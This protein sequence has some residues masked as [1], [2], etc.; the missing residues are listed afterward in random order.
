[1]KK[2][3]I[4]YDDAC[5]MCS[6]YTSAFVKTGLLTR[7][8][9]QSFSGM[10]DSL[11]KLI[12]SNKCRNEIPLVNVATG[13]VL[14]GIDAML[15]VLGNKLPIIKTI[16]N[17]AAVKCCLQ[18]CYKFISYN[19]RSIVAVENRGAK[20]NVAPDFNLVYRLLFM[21]FALF[22]VMSIISPFQ[23]H[24]LANMIT[25][26]PRPIILQV[27]FFILMAINSVGALHFLKEQAFEYL[28]QICMVTLLGALLMIP[29][30]LCN[31]WLTIG[32]MPNYLYCGAV[33][34]LLTKEYLRRITFAGLP[35]TGNIVAINLTSALVLISIL[36]KNAWL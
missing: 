7:E 21:V 23:H 30:I 24:V 16:G 25:V 34:L 17:I 6:A 20:I 3:V 32:A 36:F 2:Q 31:K 4:I 33:I 10:D 1:M 35:L 18:R 19:R 5:P 27:C 13:Q 11:L 26:P 9:R 15:E 12:D 29:L 8:E 22:T 14:Y 28:A